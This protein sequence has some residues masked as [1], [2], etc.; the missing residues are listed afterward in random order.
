[1][2]RKIKIAQTAEKQ[3][4]RLNKITRERII[5]FLKKLTQRS[6]RHTGKALKGNK[7]G[8]W[9][10]RVGDYRLICVIE[11]NLEQIVVLEIGHR[12]E[13]YR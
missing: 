7:E 1:V 2:T 12:R 9:R 13:V 10:Y 8:L 11:D 4:L 6:P 5:A 3:L